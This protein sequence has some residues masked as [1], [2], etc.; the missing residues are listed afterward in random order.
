MDE[1]TF[2]IHRYVDIVLL[3]LYIVDNNRPVFGRCCDER[4]ET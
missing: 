2:N 1:V 3:V 4:F